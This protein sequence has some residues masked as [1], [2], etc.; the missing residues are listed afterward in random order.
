M[1]KIDL[2]QALSILANLGV[3]AGIVFLA[4][5][6]GQNQ[7]ALEEQNTLTRISGR[8]AALEYFSSHR[9]TL[10]DNPDLL[11]MRLKARRG[12]TLTALEQEQFFLLCQDYAFLLVTVYNRFDSL[13]LDEER[14]ALIGLA[15]SQFSVSAADKECW[16]S[17]KNGM[18]V[19][20]YRDFVDAV[21]SAIQ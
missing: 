3:I 5:E 12:E 21:D 11:Q 18:L 14:E 7:A 10:L 8:D 19:R 16:E 13:D 2:G 17:N 1:K 9:K 6:V 20:G 15:A 4:I